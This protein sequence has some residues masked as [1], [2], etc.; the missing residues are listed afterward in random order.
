MSLEEVPEFT[1]FA[2]QSREA[3]LVSI[4]RQP[5]ASTIG[6]A[7]QVRRW[8]AESGAVLPADV[9][10]ET[11]YDQSDLVRASI[12]SVGDSL[13]IGALIAILALS[14]FLGSVRLGLAGAVL[15]PGSIVLTLL[16][17]ALIGQSLNMMTL[18]GIA[19]AVGLV[20]DDAVVVL[21]HLAHRAAPNPAALDVSAAMAEIFPSLLGS[22]LCTIVI[23]LPFMYLDGVAGAFFRVLALTMTLM[24]GSSLL[25]CITAIPLL[26]R[27]KPEPTLGSRRTASWFAQSIQ[28]AVDHPWVAVVPAC[29]LIASVLPLRGSLG[30]GFLPDMD[31]GSLIMD[32]YSPAGTSIQETDRILTEV[33]REISATPEIEA[34]SR[35]TGEQLGFFITEPNHGDYVLR[36]RPRRGR[37]ANEIADDLRRRI[38][39]SQ[40]ALRVEFGQLVEDV[41]GDLTTSP[42]PIEMR[43]FSEDRGFLAA[44]AR[45]AAEPSRAF[46]AS[47]TST[48]ASW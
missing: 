30:T 10:D 8:L 2:A 15:L 45:Q 18:G 36:L 13:L 27:P 21:E 35:R 42:Q 5:T 11:F 3:V 41:I 26:A 38:T 6:L 16:G 44:K 14:L 46:A 28:Y 32:F 40:A 25:L 1:R 17:L 31:E 48:M 34:W 24:L 39:H 33:E 20:L 12:G 29:I 37:S 43:I 19:A 4:L 9:H 47:W 23:F 7:N 22:S